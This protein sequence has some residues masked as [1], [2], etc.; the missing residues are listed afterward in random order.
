MAKQVHRLR[1]RDFLK[2][3]G[4]LAGFALKPLDARPKEST[5]SPLGTGDPSTALDWE[6]RS[7]FGGDSRF[8]ALR[9]ARHWD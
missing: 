2:A 9:T 6:E 7:N 4:S 8:V 5:A 1:R 3:G